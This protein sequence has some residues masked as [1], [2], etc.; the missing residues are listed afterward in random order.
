MD[1]HSCA[2]GMWLHGT[3]KNAFPQW[4]ALS[5]LHKTFHLCVAEVMEE[6]ET[7]PT[8]ARQML[9]NGDVIK[10]SNKLQ[11]M[12]EEMINKEKKCVKE[13]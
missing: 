12:L 11:K 8:E 7:N 13:N 2:F 1:D 9:K 5:N 10:A 6:A 3:G 4:S